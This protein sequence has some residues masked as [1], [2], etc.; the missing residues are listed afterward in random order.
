M[1]M[2]RGAKKATLNDHLR[3]M[4]TYGLLS[5]LTEVRLRSLFRALEQAGLTA[6][7]GGAE[8][9]LLTPTAK[10]EQVMKGQAP[11]VLS[12]AGWAAPLEAPS[13]AAIRQRSAALLDSLSLGKPDKELYDKLAELRRD[14]AAEHH[15]PPFRI[16]SNATLRALATIKPTTPDAAS[17]IK[18][19]G[20]W[21]LAHTIRHFL[22]VI[23]DHLEG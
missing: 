7:D 19:I 14:L 5:A 21:T 4:S 18:G 8:L 13:V 6:T 15:V 2:L 10:G 1:D 9:P 12:P 17:R 22:G 3:S 23:T 11:A 20:A 16:M